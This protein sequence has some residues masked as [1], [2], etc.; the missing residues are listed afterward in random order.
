LLELL[1]SELKSSE[2]REL[3]REIIL[4]SLGTTWTSEESSDV[5]R[6]VRR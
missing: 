6:R 2:R 1:G 3:R 5:P 4:R